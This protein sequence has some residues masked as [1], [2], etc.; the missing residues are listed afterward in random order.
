MNG[1]IQSNTNCRFAYFNLY[2]EIGDGNIND[3]EINI[4]PRPNFCYFLLKT[5][6]LYS[7]FIVGR[8]LTTAFTTSKVSSPGLVSV[9]SVICLELVKWIFRLRSPVLQV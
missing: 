2:F 5:T 4:C 8:C 7:S 3:S 9:L 6:D 1:V